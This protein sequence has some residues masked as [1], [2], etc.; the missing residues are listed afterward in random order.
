MA[1]YEEVDLK[2]GVIIITMLKKD[3]LCN[4]VGTDRLEW[5]DAL[6]GLGILL[7]VLGH[8]PPSYYIEKAIY[9][10]HMP[11]LFI[12]SG[13]LWKK[14]KS[15]KIKKY[16]QRL[17]IPYFILCGIIANDINKFTLQECS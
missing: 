14:S 9:G 11:L 6:R 3:R 8:V 1:Y 17:I 16:F 4:H 12:L 13:Y 5:I 7:V 15:L 10:F 2:I